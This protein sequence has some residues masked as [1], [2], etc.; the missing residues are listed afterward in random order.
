[1][2]E[3]K[4]EQVSSNYDQHQ[5]EEKILK[6]WDEK[7]IFKL[8]L[9]KN[10]DKPKWSFFDGPITAN[11][12]MGVHHAWGRTYKDIY[13]RYK[14]MCGFRLRYQ[15]GFDCQ[16]LW[17][18][19]EV[20]KELNLNSKR[21]II[22]FGLDKFSKACRKRVEKYSQVIKNQSIRL[23]Q[24]MDWDHSYYTMSDT[25]IQYIWYF[26]KKCWEKGWI[27]QGHR[28]MQWCPRC[29]TS[30]SQHEMTD[31][32]K[33]MSH[34]SIFLA[35]PLKNEE[36]NHFLVWTTTPWTLTSNT[37]LAVH[38]D[39]TYV[40]V[41]DISGKILILSKG[42]LQVLNKGYEILSEHKGEEF[43]DSVYN[44]PFDELIPQTD[45]KHK[46]IP[47]EAVGEEEGTG[48]VHIAPGCG[49][50]DF[51]L[52]KLHNL[53][54]IAPVD[55]DGYFLE[56]FGFLA[57]K[58]SNEARKDI[59][60]NLKEK[61]YYYKVENYIHRYPVCWRCSKELIFR[62][63]DEWFI[64]T[65]N[66]R[67]KLKEEAS[68]VIW[69]PEYMGK[70]MQDWLS[71]MGHW[72][73]S[74]R[75]FWGL[76]L[77]FYKCEK[78]GK[79]TV[80][81][82]KN[83]LK[84]KALEG[85]IDELHELHRPWI[86]NIVIECEHCKSKAYRIKD[87]GDC[88]LD[89]G[90]IPFSTLA[91][92]NIAFEENQLE[93]SH[94]D[95]EEW[96]PADWVSE[97]REQIRLWFYT[98]LYMSVTLEGKTP[99][100]KVLLYEKVMDEKGNPMHKSHGNAIWFDEA[101]DKMG[102]DVMRWL[103]AG[104]NNAN[105]L[106]FGFGPAKEIKRKLL[107]LW[108]S[109]SFF[110]LYAN[111]DK[112]SLND[113]FCEIDIRSLTDLDKWIISRLHTLIKSCRKNLDNF[114]IMYLIKTLEVFFDE[115]SNWYIRR[116]RRRF[117]K[118]ENDQD[119]NAAYKTLFTVLSYLTRLLAPITP[120]IAEELFQNL[121]KGLLEDKWETSVH[122]TEYP[123]PIESLIDNKLEEKMSLAQ[124]IVKLGLA[125]RNEARINVRQPLAEIKVKLPENLWNELLK[126]TE[127][128][129][130]NDVIKEE[131]NIKNI[132]FLPEERITDYI[133]YVIK[134]DFQILG[135]RLGKD[136]KAVIAALTKP[137]SEWIDMVKNGSSFAIGDIKI[138][139]SEVQ[140][141]IHSRQDTI[142][143]YEEDI[144]VILDTKITRE[145]EQE[146]LIREVVRNIQVLRK[147]AKLDVSDRINLFIEADKEI[148]EAVEL[149]EAY[150]KDETLAVALNYKLGD[151]L[152][153]KGNLK[154]KSSEVLIGLKKAQKS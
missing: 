93:K 94:K 59:F 144:F 70:R 120:F 41:K 23:G 22:N 2:S 58:E 38:P 124:L 97:M 114:D 33:E 60:I 88:W 147:D 102:A 103:Y 29:G 84:E 9:E 43:I 26:L 73:I 141:E 108:N 154:I 74:R 152:T 20:E 104:A 91:Y 138:S 117:W 98:L 8:L 105:N 87:V 146:G 14:A 21:D 55:E 133:T 4:F 35:L 65:D 140:L 80:I 49:A 86:D 118:S 69:Q 137:N 83:D 116:S 115:L 150:I 113:P 19:V 62:L 54:V 36:N 31:S 125:A 12:P 56:N 28:V 127:G 82:S 18:E 6:F 136:L 99:Y 92:K 15:N 78:C 111:L 52:G 143:A 112:P 101:V 110:I 72:C 145:L 57:G 45:V 100:K 95:W 96:Y 63:V 129:S 119:K 7:S 71:N 79:Y 153:A 151:D 126:E 30:L 39:L 149:F 5:I 123:L 75:R 16:G 34:P 90:I 1:M 66:I 109:Y 53:S 85:N 32:Y 46:V 51:E 25:N 121:R 13:Q 64:N 128:S 37:A 142:C 77:P 50:E 89:A 106:N 10:K 44:G 132:S 81:K 48:I 42:C 68:K 24:W 134:P 139:A 131:L 27:Y 61:G 76:P 11:N 107:T 130:L 3:N 122:L 17:V 47:W 135:K 40:R 148:T 67:E